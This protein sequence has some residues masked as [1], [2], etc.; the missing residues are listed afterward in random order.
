M[1]EEK[2]QRS[3]VRRLLALIQ[4]EYQSAQQ[5]L[6]GLALGT[7]QH[8]F[9]TQRMENMGRYHKEL[10]NIV[11]EMPAIAMIAEQLNAVP[12]PGQPVPE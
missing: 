7:S 11:G 8:S 10:Q 9:I 12:A 3:E 1:I 6:S 2:E 4:A 5:G